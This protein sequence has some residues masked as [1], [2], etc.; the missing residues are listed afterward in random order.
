MNLKELYD[1]LATLEKD[2]EDF[3]VP[4]KMLAMKDGRLVL[5]KGGEVDKSILSPSEV[6]HEQLS[7][8]LLIPKAYYDRMRN[9]NSPLLDANVNSWLG[10]SEKNYLLRTYGGGRLSA[11][12]I[13]SDR[14]HMLDNLLVLREMLK[15]IDDLGYTN[16]IEIKQASLTERRMYVELTCP[17]V[18][19][20]ATE[21]L[22]MYRPALT[23]GTGVVSGF[24]MQNSEVG[25]G[26]YQLTPR[27]VIL[28]CTNGL[29]K[30]DA[31]LR[32][33]HL[34]VKLNDG[35]DMTGSKEIREAN[36]TL[37]REQIHF[38]IKTFLS[39]NYLR[40]LVQYYENMALGQ[41][42]A[43]VNKL[44]RVVADNFGWSED[45]ADNL[46]MKFMQGGDMRRIGIYNSITEIAQGF[47][48]DEKY[49]AEAAGW[50]VL[51]N[52]E[53]FEKLAYSQILNN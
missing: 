5:L 6:F 34:G 38:A 41:I 49:Q 24:M 25:K 3:V 2:K 46:L 19:M 12:A 42:Q 40:S 11:R 52:F 17:Q 39:D 36:I 23:A 1:E 35:L 32:K 50:E 51:H 45:D 44:C 20:E 9:T 26:A 48:P 47:E 21:L 4:G 15:A 16:S 8:R 43:P 18:Q 13:L 28:A 22:K 7:E 10:R 14:H 33:I 29:I 37:I 31:A 30:P 53:K 27:A